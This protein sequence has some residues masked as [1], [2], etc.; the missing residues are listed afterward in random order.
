[1]TLCSMFM[2][3]I[4]NVFKSVHFYQS[5]I[6]SDFT[7]HTMFRIGTENLWLF[8]RYFIKINVHLGYDVKNPKS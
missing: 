6:D 4:K 5:R 2:F 7:L 8:K 1:M 3:F